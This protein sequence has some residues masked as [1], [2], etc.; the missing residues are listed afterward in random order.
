MS[1]VVCW[2]T[3]L[4]QSGKSTLARRLE[5]A[6]PAAA[7]CVR[8]DSDELREALGAEG[9]EPADRAELYATLTALAA[10]LARG[11]HVVVVAATAPSQSTRTR[12]RELAPRFLE[13]WVR[14]S[15]T[16]CMA[17]D[18]K[19]LYQRAREGLAPHLPGV[20]ARYEEPTAAEVIADGGHD[21]RAL[22]ELVE[23][24]SG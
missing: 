12:A 24:L 5:A 11:G 23:R 15:L 8:L 21:E 18:R 3:G 7:R 9:Y 19:G 2:L 1:G 10:L 13:V 14:T 4:P 22:A 17:R 6:L 16:D 20:G